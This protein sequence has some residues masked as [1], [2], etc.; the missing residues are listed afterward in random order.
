MQINRAQ[1]GTGTSQ[2]TVAVD[3]PICW[4]LHAGRS[5]CCQQSFHG[6]PMLGQQRSVDRFIKSLDDQSIA[7]LCRDVYKRFFEQ[8]PSGQNF[9]KQSTTRLYFIA[10]KADMAKLHG[11]FLGATWNGVAWCF[12]V[13]LRCSR[14]PTYCEACFGMLWPGATQ[15][16]FW[17]CWGGTGLGITSHQ[18]SLRDL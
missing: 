16:C 3:S 1:C 6:H 15:E 8:A 2:V 5:A 4:M 13:G 18:C 7:K 12:G 11:W 9:F 17:K 10:G 14:F